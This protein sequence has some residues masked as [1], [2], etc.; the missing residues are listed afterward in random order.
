[1][2]RGFCLRSTSFAALLLSGL[3]LLQTGCFT[4]LF[5]GYHEARGALGDVLFNEPNKPDGLRP[6]QAVAFDGLT[7]EL[8]RDLCPP[9][10]KRAYDVALTTQARELKDV[11]PGGAPALRVTS[12][13]VYFQKKSLLGA[14]M[15]LV[16]VRFYE[17]ERPVLDCVV[18][19]ES[20]AFSAGGE[21]SLSEAAVKTLGKLL[22]QVKEPPKEERRGGDSRGRDSRRDDSRGGDSRR[23]DS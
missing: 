5:Q 18:R 15:L 3:A 16:R 12:Q 6:Y 4:V 11:Y 8:N 14:A 23:D 22:R 20:E 13:A 19:V 10:V 7:T 2:A 1:M 17:G 9:D 21:H